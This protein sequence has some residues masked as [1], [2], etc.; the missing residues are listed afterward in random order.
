LHPPG[1]AGPGVREH[2]VIPY[3]Q[4][5]EFIRRMKACAAG[6]VPGRAGG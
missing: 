6:A 4:E 2:L 3:L 5:T 1:L